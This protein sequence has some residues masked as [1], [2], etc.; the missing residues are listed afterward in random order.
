MRG[1]LSSRNQEQTE[2][3]SFKGQEVRKALR[4][5]PSNLKRYMIELTRFGYVK[6]VGGSK[7]K[8]YEYQ[9]SDYKEYESLRSNIDAQLA[10]IITRLKSSNPTQFSG[11]V[12]Q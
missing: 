3:L 4:L 9:V 12:V 2:R 1:Y 10:A 7:H 11:S 8:G 5:H 6:V